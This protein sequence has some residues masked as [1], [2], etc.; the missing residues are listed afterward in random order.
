MIERS[1]LRRFVV[2]ALKNGADQFISVGRAVKELVVKHDCFPSKEECEAAGENYQSYYALKRLDPKDEL[3]IDEILWDLIVERVLTIGKD[4]SNEK[5]PWIRLTEFGETVIKDDQAA[6]YYDPDGFC[7][8]LERDIPGLDPVIKQYAA[9]G[10][11]CFRQRLFFAA[12]VMI[13]AAAE[14]AILLLLE[15]IAKVETDKK[16]KEDYYQLLGRPSLPQ[17]FAAIQSFVEQGIK[18]KEL[19]YEVHQGCT[20]HLLSLFETVRVQRNDAVH[21]AAG[22]VSKEKVFLSIQALPAALATVYRL[23]SWL[24]AK[25]Q[26][27]YP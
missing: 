16:K 11:K 14:S 12:A 22:Q 3:M 7:R 23:S 26:K 27:K 18:T 21:P 24:S 15:N 25:E 13:G 20:E 6:A 2:E 1:L 9:E 4:A 17:I 10:L 5:Y 8:D 19:P